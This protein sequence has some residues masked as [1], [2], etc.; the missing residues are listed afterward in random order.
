MSD[1]EIKMT[2]QLWE[3][4]IEQAQRVLDAFLK[5]ESAAFS[6]LKIPSIDLNY[7][8]ESVMKLAHY[9]VDEIKAG[10]FDEE[11]QNVWIARLGYYFG[12]AL[13]VAKPSLSWG[14]GNPE[15]AFANHPVIAGF[16]GGEEAEVITI[17]KNIV[18]SVAEGRSPPERIENAVELWFGTPVQA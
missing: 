8:A 6:D 18:R 4:S 11:L 17:S 16:A 2:D 15:Y 5:T 14:L 10:Q 1:A 12:E 3:L 7:S 9:V 13:R